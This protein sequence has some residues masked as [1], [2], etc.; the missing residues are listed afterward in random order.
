MVPDEAKRG[1]SGISARGWARGQFWTPKEGQCSEPKHTLRFQYPTRREPWICLQPQQSEAKRRWPRLGGNARHFRPT[2][3]RPNYSYGAG[4]Q[5]S[6]GFGLDIGRCS[7]T[8]TAKH[9]A[10]RGLPPF[11]RKMR[12]HS[13]RP[14][15]WCFPAEVRLSRLPCLMV[16]FQSLKWSW[17]GAAENGTGVSVHPKETWSCRARKAADPQPITKLTGRSSCCCCPRRIDRSD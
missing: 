5:L 11:Q 15:V 3:S 16:G 13:H 14:F 4:N 9:V 2:N 10:Q 17:R 1:K 12:W 6:H 8:L 7:D